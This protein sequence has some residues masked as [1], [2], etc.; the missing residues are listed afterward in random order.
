M[1]A[2]ILLIVLALVATGCGG[3]QPS[4]TGGGGGGGGEDMT[5]EIESPQ[6]GAEV[7]VPFTIELASSEEIGPP[8]SGAHHVH[9]YFDDN[10]DDYIVVESTSYEV[11][12]LPSGEHEIYASLRNADHSETG[13][14]V[15]VEVMVSGGTMGG[16]KEKE[17]GGGYDY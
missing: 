7:S 9:I 5:L 10:E 6:S 1:R 2:K 16:D 12:D 15:E 17:D 4:G 11:T 14:E 3:P 13:V 8:D